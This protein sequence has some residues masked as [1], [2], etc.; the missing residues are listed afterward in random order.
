M[1]LVAVGGIDIRLIFKN[2]S[3]F[4]TFFAMSILCTLYFR[5]N[6]SNVQL[7]FCPLGVPAVYLRQALACSLQ[8]RP[9]MEG[10]QTGHAQIDVRVRRHWCKL[11]INPLTDYNYHEHTGEPG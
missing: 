3:S 4:C 5:P 1:H 9:E 2:H 6:S 10:T 11:R 7:I 8:K